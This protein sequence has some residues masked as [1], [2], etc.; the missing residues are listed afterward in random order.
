MPNFGEFISNA[1]VPPAVDAF[2]ILGYTP[3]PRQLAF[4][5]AS[6]ERLDA[7]LYGGAAG[8]GKSCAFVMDAIW[9]ATNFPGMKIGCF[10]R[11]YNELEES[12]LAELA[13][14]NYARAVGAKW[15]S[16][17]R[18]LKFP[19]GSVINFSYA[20]NLVDASRILGGE[21]QAFYIDEASLM[22][23]V[24]IQHIEER[25]RSGNRLVPVIGLRLATNPGGVG[26]KY[27]KDRFVNP[28]KRGKI[29]H[30]EI[31]EGT[32]LSRTVAFIPAKASDNP[33]INESYDVVLNSIPDPQRRAAMRD[34]DWDAMVGQFFEQWQFSKHVVQSF[35]IPKEWPRY[36][37]IDYGYAAPWAVVWLAV[38]NDGRIWVYR[39]AY[40]TKVNA[41]Y[42]AKIILETEKSAG[43]FEVIRVADPS[44][45]GSRGTPLSIADIY[46][47]EGCG[48]MPADNDRINGWSRVHHYLND[49]PACEI[50]RQAGL[51]KCPMIHVFEDK[52][53]MF[54]ETIPA[55]PRSSAKPDDA[56]TKNVDDHIA[57]ALRYVIMAVGT[58]ARP[59]LYD[60][61]PRFK[62][63][64]FP[65][66]MAQGPDHENE[67]MALPMYGGGKFVG[68]FNSTSP[69]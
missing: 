39:E 14:R 13:K 49:G 60:E 35:P 4:H 37:G 29:R 27:L 63:I 2:E 30:S 16:T 58:Y 52:C 34:G 5:E 50:H 17:N 36:A 53:P 7:I 15:N 26:H 44:M 54:I 66:T 55:L 51:D 22:L 67:G 41:D 47:Q 46:G 65:N 18:V 23:P 69:F 40:S 43:E 56:E 59:I 9:N 68:D 10:R 45:W 38:D 48:I 8:G 62:Q 19:N 57:D 33:H 1:V 61:E 64:G 28:T 31:V 24:V 11:T 20:E 6:R 32:N 42:Q 21:Y 25:L 12:F 3:T